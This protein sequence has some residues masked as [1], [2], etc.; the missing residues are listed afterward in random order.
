MFPPGF[1]DWFEDEFVVLSSEVGVEKP[2]LRIFSIAVA[3]TRLTA[4]RCMFVGENLEKTVAAQRIG[5]LAV[6]I[7]EHEEDFD[8]LTTLFSRE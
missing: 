7:G 2:E 5:M 4:R 3:R 6:R 8:D 1:F